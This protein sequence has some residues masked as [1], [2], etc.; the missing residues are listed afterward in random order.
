MIV[1]IALIDA[2]TGETLL[3]TLVNPGTARVEPEARAVHG[4]SDTELAAAPAC[5]EEVWRGPT[6]SRPP[7]HAALSGAS[8]CRGW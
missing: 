4:I 5:A 7:F 3:D 6:V 8:A 1:E 2:A